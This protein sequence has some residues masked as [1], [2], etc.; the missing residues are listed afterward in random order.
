MKMMRFAKWVFF[1]AGISGV[2]LMVPPLGDVAER[3]ST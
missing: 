1:F 2:I 3:R